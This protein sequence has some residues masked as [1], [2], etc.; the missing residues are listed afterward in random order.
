ME[1]REA[2]VWQKVMPE[3]VCQ[4]LSAVA[5][6]L[7]SRPC[8]QVSPMHSG[9]IFKGF[10]EKLSSSMLL[11]SSKSLAGVPSMC[12]E[13]SATTWE[14]MEYFNLLV[15]SDGALLTTYFFM[16]LYF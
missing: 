6:A 16:E 8:S 2:L 15:H 1:E 14:W 5:I 4:D 13:A 10:F 3:V 12:V 9:L 11:S 7:R